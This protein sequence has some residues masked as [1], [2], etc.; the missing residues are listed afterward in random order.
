MGGDCHYRHF[1]VPRNLHTQTVYLRP[2]SV[3]LRRGNGAPVFGQ[4]LGHS[5]GVPY[6]E[7]HSVGSSCQAGTLL[8]AHSSPGA[9]CVVGMD[10]TEDRADKMPLSRMPLGVV[11]GSRRD[12]NPGLI[13]PIL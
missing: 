5:S 8:S 12:S 13:W 10:K 9:L 1:L 11:V 2:A 4:S 3:W 6:L 7:K